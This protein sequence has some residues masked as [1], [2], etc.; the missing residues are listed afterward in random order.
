M[1]QRAVVFLKFGDI[2]V[3]C[4]ENKYFWMS[5]QFQMQITFKPSYIL[6]LLKNIFRKD[7]CRCL[8]ISIIFHGWQCWYIFF[9]YLNH[10]IAHFCYILMSFKYV[11]F[12]IKTKAVN[13]WQIV[14]LACGR[15]GFDPRSGQTSVIW[16]GRDNST[17][18]LSSTDAWSSLK[19]CPMSRK[20]WHFQEHSQVTVMSST[21][22][23]K[24]VALRVV[25]I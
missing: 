17:T 14:C 10:L 5:F 21:Y 7:I 19:G 18:N 24:C 25:L 23:S 15:W 13:L 12:T 1:L 11:V 9:S 22:I 8:F 4:R 6:K 2:S 20:H 16:T 3:I